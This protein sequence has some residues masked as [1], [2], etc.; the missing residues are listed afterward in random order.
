MEEDACRLFLCVLQLDQLGVPR[1][2]A[3]KSTRKFATLYKNGVASPQFSVM[4]SISDV[5]F[6]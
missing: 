2:I 6:R 5:W 1:S 3:M 4:L